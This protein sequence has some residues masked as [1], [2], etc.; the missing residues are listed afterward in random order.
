MGLGLGGLILSR[1]TR[2]PSP[3]CLPLLGRETE[4]RPLESCHA[5]STDRY[6][7][8]ELQAP[9]PHAFPRV[10]TFSMRAGRMRFVITFV[11]VT[12]M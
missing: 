6:E 11:R 12:C 5:F 9:F 7:S 10:P 8:M 4:A 1:S 2:S 3:V